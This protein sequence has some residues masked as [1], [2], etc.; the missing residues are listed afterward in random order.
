VA[1]VIKT[2]HLHGV[3][4]MSHPQT[5]AYLLCTSLMEVYFL[6]VSWVFTFVILPVK[7]MS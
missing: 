2:F 4:E 6:A 7:I 5:V 1:S 3:N